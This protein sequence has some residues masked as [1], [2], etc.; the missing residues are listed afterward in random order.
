MIQ[1]T[2][3]VALS[4][5]NYSDLWPIFIK[6]FQDNWADCPF[7]KYISSNQM[8]YEN[9][10]FSF[11]KIGK[12][13]SWSDGVI[14][15]LNLLKESYDYA[16]VTLEDLMLY[17]KVDTQT[18]LSMCNEFFDADGNYIK[19]I[20]KPSPT[21]KFN[22]DFGE[23]EPGSLYR[24]TCVYALWKID[25]LLDLLREEENAWQFERYGAVRSEKYAGFYVVYKDFFSVLNTVVKG[26]WVPVEL[27][28]LT[29]LGHNLIPEREVMGSFAALK[30]YTYALL[31]RLS[32]N[33]IPWKMRKKL[34]FAIKKI[35]S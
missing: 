19:F 18:F 32:Y 1:K 26:R 16:L 27:K 6:Q 31:Y 20:K 13:N 35:K 14:K 23:I 24:P 34:V 7:D 17:K 3:L 12:D 33:F 28:K 21:K 15:T 5:D 8:E 29:R 2:A 30:L 4:C 11:I 25:V 22:Q 10:E 9:E